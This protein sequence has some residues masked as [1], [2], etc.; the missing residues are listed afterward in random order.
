MGSTRISFEPE[1][2]Y[3][4]YNR[5]VGSDKL[6]IE[7]E[8]YHFFLKKFSLR[9]TVFADILA[10]CLMPNH[11]H[12]IIRIKEQKI[13]ESIWPPEL[14]LKKLDRFVFYDKMIIHQ[15]AVIFNS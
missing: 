4:I 9:I 11:F 7:D 13:L 8:N 10:Y 14:N 3:H 12:F 15:F 6:F 2:I 1:G 5:A